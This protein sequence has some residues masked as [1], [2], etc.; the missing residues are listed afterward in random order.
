M[1][2][3]FVYVDLL[4]VLSHPSA[5]GLYSCT[6][7]CACVHLYVCVHTR[8]YHED[9]NVLINIYIRILV[10][11]RVFKVLIYAKVCILGNLRV[12]VCVCVHF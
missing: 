4:D 8:S 2:F 9:I 3:M 6:Y 1:L 10:L 12:C 11:R 7:V 5:S